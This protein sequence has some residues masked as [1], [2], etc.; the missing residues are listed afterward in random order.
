MKKMMMVA[1]A[2]AFTAVAQAASVNWKIGSGVVTPSE[3]GS[4]SAGRA[5]YY[6]ALVFTAD[7]LDAVTAALG[8]VA[9]GGDFTS[10]NAITPKSQYQAT[11]A[12][13]FSGR[14]DGVEGESASIFTVIFD[15]QATGDAITSATHYQVSSAISQSTYTPPA[16]ATTAEFTAA[17]IGNDW[18]AINAAPEPTSGLLLLLGMAGLALKR[19]Q[20]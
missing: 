20:A 15:T 9:N 6:T 13:T 14:V 1:V 10:F 2:I 11:K 8:S 17:S 16:T 7:Q 3:A 19:K 18:T 4:A 5:S 12:G